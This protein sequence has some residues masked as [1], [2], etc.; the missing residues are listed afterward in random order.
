MENFYPIAKIAC[1]ENTATL[2]VWSNQLEIVIKAISARR[3]LLQ[4]ILQL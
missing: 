2:M 4:T 3:M 1:P